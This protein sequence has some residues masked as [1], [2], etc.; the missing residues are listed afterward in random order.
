MG[1]HLIFIFFVLVAM[2]VAPIHTAATASKAKLQDHIKALKSEKAPERAM[3]AH[4]LAKLGPTAK[5]AIPFLTPMLNDRI[6]LHWKRKGSPYVGARTTPAKEATN[7][8]IQ[9][10]KAAVPPVIEV[11]ENGDSY[12]R[13]NASKILLALKDPR[14]IPPLLAALKDKET[15][16]RNNAARYFQQ[17]PDKRAVDPLIVVLN[18]PENLVRN[19]AAVTLG[20]IGDERAVKPLIDVMNKKNDK[21]AW[22]AAQALGDIGGQHAAD[23]LSKLL[24]TPSKPLD[25]RGHAA[26]ALAKT[27]DKRAYDLALRF[28]LSTKE[29]HP[30][31]KA[32]KAMEIVGDRRAIPHIIKALKDPDET[33]QRG[34]TFSLIH[35]GGDK[36]RTELVRIITA[37]ESRQWQRRVIIT[38]GEARNAWAIETLIGLLKHED[39]FVRQQTVRTL[40]QKTTKKKEFGDTEFEVWKKWFDSVKSDKKQGYIR[41]E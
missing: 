25:I 5:S 15:W 18:D 10:G 27:G 22:S 35:F 41:R 36:A 14:A 11:L 31:L 6:L 20:K 38:I 23:A 34:A 9:I 12:S 7:A 19:Q 28:F 8:L 32:M 13:V 37:S 16:V 17:I 40:R 30:R 2:L 1:R 29:K 24:S 3:A 39:A 4:E 33:I 21:A 26:L